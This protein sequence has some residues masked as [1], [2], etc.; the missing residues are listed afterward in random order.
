MF[1]R[2]AGARALSVEDIPTY[3][4]EVDS[5]EDVYFDKVKS[6]NKDK[7]IRIKGLYEYMNHLNPP[8]KE[9]IHLPYRLLVELAE[10]APKNNSA[11]Y[12]AKKLIEYQYV[13]EIDDNIVNKIIYFIAL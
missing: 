10:I 11:D 2:I 5:V 8:E 1:K 4:D 13:K 12:I 9:S 3:M 6:E 7:E